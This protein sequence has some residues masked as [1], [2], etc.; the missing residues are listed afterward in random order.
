ML[1]AI[2]KAARLAGPMV[3]LEVA[4]VYMLCVYVCVGCARNAPWFVCVNIIFI[5]F[6]ERGHTHTLSLLS[7]ADTRTIT[8]KHTQSHTL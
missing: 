6:Y 8:H 1:E 7:S 4:E 3:P 5:Y 2:E